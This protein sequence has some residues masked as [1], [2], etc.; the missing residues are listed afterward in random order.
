MFDASFGKMVAPMKIA[1]IG[2]G[3]SGLA[4]GY[5]LKN[6]FRDAAETTLYEQSDRVGGWIRSVDEK[7]FLFEKGPRS[8]RTTG[9]GAA[10]L[11]LVRD[12]GLQNDVLLGEKSAHARYLFHNGK[13]KKLPG[14]LR[15]CVTSPWIWKALPP[16][17]K[18]WKIPPSAVEDET[19]DAFFRRRFNPF[20]ADTL[21]DPLVNGIYAGDPKKLSLSSCFPLLKEMERE[22]GSVLKA[23]LRK[24]KKE[25]EDPFLQRMQRSGLFTFKRGIETLVQALE[26]QL[27]DNI[28]KNAPI[29]SL[30]H[31][32][33]DAVVFALPAFRLASLFPSDP[34]LVG[35]LQSIRYTDLSVVNIGYEQAVL[36]VRGFGH[37]VPSKEPSDILGVVWDSSAF[38][39]QNKRKGETRLTVMLGGERRPD[40]YLLDEKETAALALKEVE[41][42]LGIDQTPSTIQCEKFA[43]AIPQFEIGHQKKVQRIEEK[44]KALSP[45]YF[46]SGNAFYGVSVNDC[47]KHSKTLAVNCEKQL[48]DICKNKV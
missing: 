20:I 34:E 26:K 18:E 10:T 31:L 40:L 8:L 23:L 42:Q 41:R 48:K 38:P 6:R 5:F 4:A 16:L 33:A 47:V 28:R 12:L 44:L 13:L 27:E 36:P 35:L 32:E 22:S 11:E 25:A 29:E 39:S 7:G 14:S 15:D 24:K 45:N 46:L 30:E 2:G 1:V 43:S 21:I 17:F 3:I 9:S 37:L 19:I